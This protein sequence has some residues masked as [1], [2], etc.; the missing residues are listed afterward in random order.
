MENVGK[1][2]IASMRASSLNSFTIFL[3]EGR[4]FVGSKLGS[5]RGVRSTSSLVRAKWLKGRKSN[6][7]SSIQTIGGEEIGGAEPYPK[8]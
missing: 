1:V 2:P 5:I 6:H 8:R 3:L 7:C 4:A